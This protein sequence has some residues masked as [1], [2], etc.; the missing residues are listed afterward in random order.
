MDVKPHPTSPKVSAAKA[1][2]QV[3]N[4]QKLERPQRTPWL[5]ILVLLIIVNL[6]VVTGALVGWGWLSRNAPHSRWLRWLPMGTSTT[7]VQS[8]KNPGPLTIPSAVSQALDQLVNIAPDAGPDGRYSTTSSTGLAVPL[9][10]NGWLMTLSE[11]RPSG[12]AVALSQAGVVHSV[13]TN[14]SDPGSPFAFLKTAG[15]DLSPLDLTTSTPTIGQNVWVAAGTLTDM[16]AVNRTIVGHGGP[17]WI[18]TDQQEDYWQL[19]QPVSTALGA[20]VLTATGQVIG[21]LG[22]NGRVWS[23]DDLTSVISGVLQTE[24]ISRAIFGW[25]YLMLNQSVS[26]SISQTTGALVGA[27]QGDQAVT[28]KGPADKAGLKS[29][30]IIISIDQHQLQTDLRPVLSTYHVGDHLQL[31][32]SRADKHLDLN[33]IV[34]R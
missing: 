4:E 19:D 16:T 29:G 31:T 7:V 33:V 14:L 27:D 25:R 6:I 24:K 26:T 23:V 2:A 10:T 20:P 3:W 17:R 22:A 13:A 32:I 28:P 8:V 9:S 11:A 30:D 12:T 34:G 15:A 21:L 5:G 18:S 1:V